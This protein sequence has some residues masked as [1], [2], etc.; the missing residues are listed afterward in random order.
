[1]VFVL[2]AAFQARSVSAADL[3]ILL[4][5]GRVAYQTN[6]WIDISVVRTSADG[7]RD[8]DLVLALA[9]QDG[10]RVSFTFPVRAAVGNPA[11]AT[12]HYHVNGALLRP[13]N[14]A[15]D[16]ASDGA[17]APQSQ[18]E[19][20]SHLRKSSF[21][22]I[23]WGSRASGAAQATL[24]EDSVGMNLD[25]A[26]Y[27]GLSP[28]DLIRG[29]MDYVWCCTMSGGSQMDLRR[30]CDW[31]DPYVL[32]GGIARVARRVFAD[33]AM[34]N[35]LGV[36]IYDEPTLTT[37]KDPA[38]GDTTPFNVPAQ[39]RSYK[40]AFGEDPIQYN[41]VK[42]DDPT[43]VQKWDEMQKWRL[44][45]LDAAWKLTAFTTTYVDP[46][47]LSA[48]QGDWLF[49]G[50]GQGYYFNYMNSLPVYSGHGGYDYLNGGDFAPGYFF[51]F[52]RI[53]QT[54]KPNWYLP[55]WGCAHSDLFRGEQYLSFQNNLQGID[56][57]PDLL[58]HQPSTQAASE[59]M[60]ESNKTMLRLGTIFTTM[61]VTRPE[62]AVLFSLS[63]N[64]NAELHDMKDTYYG[65][66]QLHKLLYVY[67][68][69]KILHTPFCPVVEE[70]ILDGTLAAHH[71]VLVIAGNNSLPPDVIGALQKFI[72]HGGIVLLS[73]DSQVKIPGARTFHY[74]LVG[75]DLNKNMEK[76][77]GSGQ[78]DKWNGTVV[79]SD[80]FKT[81]MAVA[82]DMRPALQAAGVKPVFGCT[83]PGIVASRQAAGDIEYLFAVNA[84]PDYDTHGWYFLHNAAVTIS[85]PDDGRPVYDAVNGGTAGAF[86]KGKGGLDGTFRFGAGQMR[87]FAR[88]ARPIGGVDLMSP[89]VSSDFS[90][91][92]DPVHLE[93]GAVL[94][95]DQ[96]QALCGSAPMR[97][98]VIDP[99]NVKRFDLYRAT[100]NG[101]LRLSLPLGANDP[102]GEWTVVVHEL[103]S[104]SG[105]PARFRYNPPAQCGAMAGET[106]RAVY[107]GN[108][109]E[110]IFR[111]FRL[112]K[113]IAIVTGTS[114]FDAAQ[115]DRLVQILKP[116][117]I[118]CTVVTAAD[119]AKPRTLTPEQAVSWVGLGGREPDVSLSSPAILLGNPDDNVLIRFLADHGFL[120][121]KTARDQFPGRGRGMMAWQDD[122]FRYFNVE[123]ISLIGYDAE[124]LAE[125]VGTMYNAMAGIDPITPLDLPGDSSVTPAIKNPNALAEPSTAWQTVLPDRL[126]GMKVLPGGQVV[127]MADDGT[128]AWIQPDG[129]IAW[130]KTFDGG[131]HWSL[132]VSED[133]SLIVVGASLRVIGLD[134]TGRQ[135][136]DVPFSSEKTAPWVTF[137]AVSPDGKKVAA[138]GGFSDWADGWKWKGSVL[139]LAPDGKTLWRAGGSD[140]EQP[141]S[142]V[143]GELIM[144][145]AFTADGKELVLPMA[146]QA[147]ILDAATGK[148]D[149]SVPIAGGSAPMLPVGQ[150]ILMA[151]GP[152]KL[153]EVSSVPD[154][155]KE[156]AWQPDLAAGDR[157]VS[158]GFSGEGLVVGTE[159]DGAVR[160]YAIPSG[161]LASAAGD[162]QK[163]V[164]QFAMPTRI[165]KKV[166][167]RGS[168]VAIAYWGGGLRVLDGAGKLV[169]GEQFTQDISGIDWSR[170]KLVVGLADGRV[171]G[172][173][174]PGAR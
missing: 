63:H 140:P 171:M 141:G 66:D 50:Y 47:F 148:H 91:K 87:V 89:V 150:Q 153:A 155:G 46:S 100:E 73:D 23:D 169:A 31:S 16:A 121:Y 165:V 107:F 5:L 24:G 139:G 99:L 144:S 119:A 96:K 54:G 36:H 173:N 61:P 95:D 13:G 48:N 32:G 86:Q 133:G 74:P 49:S 81:A 11:I 38:T 154:S 137:V 105:S 35:C 28:D 33:R 127:A 68:A 136:F 116:W 6:E 41:Q 70:Y 75:I 9:G 65:G 111:F 131:E 12:E 90:A 29:G 17:N 84:S 151:S 14:Y 170:N 20:Y 42:P 142:P 135:L 10:S 40:A 102:A 97:V 143:A 53:R 69:S 156:T 152:N 19:V 67:M 138:G 59:G 2:L 124:G 172:L 145:A 164:W 93:I 104:T 30:E 15:V 125:A 167:T 108:D 162:N 146:K 43:Q 80:F 166:A 7:L 78:W 168:V 163:P 57:P 160:Q 44:S 3:K 94:M 71:R 128:L 77:G 83:A 161:S 37:W 103:L 174:I 109:R 60:V 8:G 101:M 113:D 115:A 120:P 45:L 4:P 22:V 147:Q 34:P 129:K 72:A 122:G 1:M 123:S 18:F 76:W 118:R 85:L 52:G 58:I 158:L 149:R 130:Q 82:E 39:D 88:T 51:E 132:D 117:D 157:L 110:N 134:R 159:G 79:D 126:V 55:M 112:H 25:L 98:E 26:A 64:L 56:K 92:T 114:D 106:P 27:G 62:V 21:K